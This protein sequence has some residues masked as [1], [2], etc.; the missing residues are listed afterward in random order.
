M[1]HETLFTATKWDI[2][3]ALEK[4]PQSPIEIAKLLG[5]S[6]A[7][8]SQQLRL[9]EMAGVV[10]SKRIS[11]RDKDKPRVLY[12]LNG[13]LS[14]LIA[15]SDN[16]VDKKMLS[17]TERNKAVLRIWFLD[18]PQVRY[19]LEKAF[20]HIEPQ[21]ER[22]TKLSFAGVHKGVPVLEYLGGKLPA[23]IEVGGQYG[24]VQLKASTTPSGHVI[25]GR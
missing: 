12:S 15:T 16:F 10:T 4:R 22:I 23:F 8:V 21:L 14:Y 3:K 11:N 13:D 24:R 25:H 19:A 1:D 18:D 9:L 6:L 5:S 7:N 20:W 17:L 2:L